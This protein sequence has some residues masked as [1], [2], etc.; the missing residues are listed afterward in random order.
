MSG[1]NSTTT[2]NRFKSKVLWAAI[3]AQIIA[4]L[5]L[6]GAFKAMGLDAGL[7][8]DVIA[9]VLQLLVLFGVLNNPTDGK[10]F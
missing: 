4:L 6:T 7:A 10:N 3:A 8:G 5:E 2:Q 9:G 1:Q